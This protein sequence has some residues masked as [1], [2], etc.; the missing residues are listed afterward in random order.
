MTVVFELKS[1]EQFFFLYKTAPLE[2][3]SNITAMCNGGV[4][5]AY[6]F[7]TFAVGK[8]SPVQLPCNSIN[9]INGHSVV[10]WSIKLVQWWH[11]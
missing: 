6:V 11:N 3:R 4:P 7:S 5:N 8:V 1:Q 2:G 10:V 9:L